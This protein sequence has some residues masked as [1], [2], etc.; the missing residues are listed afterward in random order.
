M[1]I[2]VHNVATGEI[3]ERE[4]TPE[5]LAQRVKDQAETAEFRAEIVAVSVGERD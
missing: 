2:L 4:A 1:I 5:E 3:I